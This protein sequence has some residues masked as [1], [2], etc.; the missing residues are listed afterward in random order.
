MPVNS[1]P[2]GI[3]SSSTGGHAT[4][5]ASNV[6]TDRTV[7][8]VDGTHINASDSNPGTEREAPF[9]TLCGSDGVGATDGAYFTASANDIIVIGAGHQ[10][11]G[12]TPSGG[13]AGTV[14]LN[15]TKAGISIIGLG[16][17]TTR[18][19]FMG[20]QPIVGV[21]G[22]YLFNLNAAG[23]EI[24]NLRLRIRGEG[25]DQTPEIATTI[26][27]VNA[28]GCVIGECDFQTGVNP[29]TT[30]ITAAECLSRGEFGNATSMI[31]VG[32]TTQATGLRV[33][34][35]TLTNSWTG[36]GASVSP[37]YG[38]FVH[39]G[40][41]AHSLYVES[42]T[43][44]GGSG[45][46]DRGSIE[47]ASGVAATN[48]RCYNNTFQNGADIRAV[49]SFRGILS[50][51]TMSASCRIVNDILTGYPLGLVAASD[52]G[53]AILSNPNLYITG[54]VWWVDSSDS[55]ASDTNGGTE[56]DH[57][58]ATLAQAI[59]QNTAAN[60]DLIVVESG[61][62]QTL[63][64]TVTISEADTKIFGLGTS[65]AQKPGFTASTASATP[66]FT[67]SGNGVELHGLRFPVSA[68][69]T[70]TRIRI[71]GE[72]CVLEGCDF[73][74]DTNF[75]I[76]GVDVVSGD[77]CEINN[78]TFLVST[79]PAVD[80]TDTYAIRL[81]HTAGLYNL[82]KNNTF[83]G[84]TRG[85]SNAAVVFASATQR[86]VVLANTFRNGADIG[87]PTGETNIVVAGNTMDATS[88][89]SWVI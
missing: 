3:Q 8:Y 31:L 71:T 48:F 63:T 46:F 12:V 47:F 25:G 87:I 32:N 22:A 75:D 70:A 79:A 19:I 15:I 28:Q 50:N 40:A 89:V 2:A 37:L 21:G 39:G 59:T 29:T 13:Q 34:N 67:L 65:S 9:A 24:R 26:V 72:Q 17:G 16:S 54:N 14:Q 42:C 7:Y 69:S 86:T 6:L 18:P 74:Q 4:F 85:Y 64:A 88:L 83:D 51:N 56:R 80:S 78:C 61:H 81:A 60:G 27:S 44:N 10:E 45:G 1:Y 5:T 73:T 55:L 11:I 35:C 41:T 66:L 68:I 82:V 36:T 76:L 57:P 53:H 52:G 30:S 77:E 33:E 23:V 49:T 38:I 84:G 58:L 20:M 62:A 43:L